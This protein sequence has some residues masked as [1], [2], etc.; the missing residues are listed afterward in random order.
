MLRPG[1]DDPSR[2][3]CRT[4]SCVTWADVA[5]SRGRCQSAPWFPF[6]SLTT[7]SSRRMPKCWLGRQP[8]LA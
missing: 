6:G 3:A 4:T 7:T 8:E 1:N 5:T 2:S